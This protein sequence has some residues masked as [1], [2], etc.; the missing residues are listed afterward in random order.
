MITFQLVLTGNQIRTLREIVANTDFLATLGLAPNEWQ[1]VKSVG[2]EEAEKAWFALGRNNLFITGVRGL[3]RE[4][5]VRHLEGGGYVVTDKGK[6]ALQLIELDIADF[7]KEVKPK[8]APAPEA[9][10]KK[11]AKAKASLN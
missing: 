10:G 4:G 3:I 8:E 2:G 1:R 7:H 11:K 5:L 6:L 9:N